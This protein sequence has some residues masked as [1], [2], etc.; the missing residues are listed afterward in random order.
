MR[1]SN[2]ARA[3]PAGLNG[4]SVTL[5]LISFSAWRMTMT[6]VEPA[7]PHTQ[8]AKTAKLEA[9][10]TAS[11]V[12]QIGVKKGRRWKLTWSLFI[13]ILRP[14]CKHDTNEVLYPA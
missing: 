12:N 2:A 1:A 3:S 14:P 5:T 10:T 13:G 11:A 9:K 4:G 8:T 7:V 6:V